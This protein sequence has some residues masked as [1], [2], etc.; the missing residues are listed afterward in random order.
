MTSND[1]AINT[2]VGHRPSSSELK[3]EK[4]LPV[5]WGRYPERL[6]SRG[7]CASIWRCT[8]LLPLR[9]NTAPD[10][11]VLRPLT[12][13]LV[14]YQGGQ[15]SSASP[16]N[17]QDEQP[18]GSTA[19]RKSH[20]A[21]NDGGPQSQLMES[22]FAHVFVLSPTIAVGRWGSPLRQKPCPGISSFAV[23]ISGGAPRA[24]C[25]LAGD[26]VLRGTWARHDSGS[27]QTHCNR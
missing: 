24:P 15:G 26:H 1:V 19:R 9:A 27:L 13:C 22:V 17:G 20:F 18:T 14:P 10:H 11:G 23:F 12:T 5:A 16:V 25:D 4:L 21:Q 7:G 8:K 3:V 2:T 6:G